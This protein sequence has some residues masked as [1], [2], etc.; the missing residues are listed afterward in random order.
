MSKAVTQV[1]LSVNK[2]YVK[3]MEFTPEEVLFKIY[4]YSTF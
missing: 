2:E 4:L 3:N 1:I